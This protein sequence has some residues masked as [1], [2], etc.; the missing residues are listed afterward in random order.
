MVPLFNAR[1]DTHEGDLQSFV[2]DILLPEMETVLDRLK[3]EDEATYAASRREM[4]VVMVDECES[5]A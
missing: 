5:G 3:Q 2:D 1:Y 4:G